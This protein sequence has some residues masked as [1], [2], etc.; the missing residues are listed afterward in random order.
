MSRRYVAAFF[1]ELAPSYDEWEGGL[2]RRLAQDLV[3]MANPAPGESC[4]DIGAG[5]G[6]V[7][8]L[9][10]KSVGES[11][12]VV[13]IDISERMLDVARRR[14]RA[15]TS[16]FAM[17]IDDV[18]FRDGSFD[19]VTV[20][21]S[22]A[23]LVSPLGVVAEASRTLKHGGRLALFCRRRSLSTPAER[24]FF[25]VLGRLAPRHPIQIPTHVPEQSD[26]GE[27][28]ALSG[29]LREAGL[30][31]AQ[32]AD[33]V[34]GGHVADTQQWNQLMMET[35]PAAHFLIGALGTEA[36]AAFDAELDAEMRLLGD[37]AYRY[38]HPYL[39][40]VATSATAKMAL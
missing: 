11:G 3:E 36:R 9:L 22:L 31:V 24:T 30:D 7:A 20:G 39:F 17:P 16:C 13:S 23:Y 26:L 37:D 18:V 32:F 5:T 14:A 40:A 27:R 28:A 35:W 15:N 10:S 6:L 8:E 4:L 25:T 34:T 2:R 29:L 38:H 33:M 12:Y 1:D 19:L 21:R